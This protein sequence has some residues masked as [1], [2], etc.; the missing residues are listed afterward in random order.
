MIVSM[1]L[2]G[3]ALLFLVA[4]VGYL[5]IFEIILAK[6]SLRSLKSTLFWSVY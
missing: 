6:R 5:E 2:L 1:L 3:V 4:E